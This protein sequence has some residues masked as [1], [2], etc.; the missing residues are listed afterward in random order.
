MQG[1][2]FG[3]WTSPVS[4]ADVAAAD[5]HPNWPGFVGDEVWWSERLPMDGGRTTLMRCPSG[6]GRPRS[7][8]PAPWSVR[9]RLMEYGGRAWCG[10]TTDDG[11]LAVFVHADD[12]RLYAFDPDEPAAAPRPVTPASPPGV[13]WRFADLTPAAPGGSAGHPTEVWCVRESVRRGSAPRREIV[14]VPLDGSACG[15]PEAVRVLGGG[16]DFCSG[17]ALAPDA[18]RAAWIGWD[19]PDMPWDSS[20]AY[21]ADVL[22]DG[23]LGPSR[24]VAGGPREAVAQVLWGEDGTLYAITDRSGWW[25]IH[26]APLHGG[27]ATNVCPRQEEFAGGLTKLGLTWA[28]ALPGGRLAVL[29][30][31]HDV[32]LSVLD[33]KTGELHGLN[34]ARTEW[35]PLLVSRGGRLVAIGAG[36]EQDYTVTLF[37]VTAGTST[38]LT[39][40]AATVPAAYLPRPEG[41]SFRGPDGRLVHAVVCPPRNPRHTGMPGERPPFVVFAH[42]G[43]T[44]RS[45]T[46]YDL[47]VAYLTSRGIGVVAV[48]YAGSTG[49][50]RAYREQLTHR[51]GI[52]DVADCALVAN[53]LAEE[54]TAD[55]DRLAI[56]GASAGGWTAAVS[57]TTQD[58]Y[59]CAALLYPVLDPVAWRAAQN[60]GF[61]AY[62]LD[63]LIGPWPEARQQFLERS[64]AHA[65][66]RIRAP[67]LLLQGSDDPICPPA[68]ADV[69]LA[70]VRDTVPFTRRVFDGERHGFKRSETVIAALEAELALY[71]E[72]FV[73]GGHPADRRAGA[74]ST[75]R[76]HGQ[77][78]CTVLDLVRDQARRT[79]D[80]VAVADEEG[81]WTYGELLRSAAESARRLGA[82]GARPGDRVAIYLHR[83]RDLVA[84]MLAAWTAGCAY[85]PLDPEYPADRLAFMLDDTRPAAVLTH[86]GLPPLLP[87]DD[88]RLVYVDR[89]GD[90]GPD[91]EGP[92]GAED[93]AF[94][95]Y[96]SGSTGVPKGV[97]LTHRGIAAVLHYSQGHFGFTESDAVLALA[98]VS[99]DFAQLEILL[100][101]ISGGTVHLVDR[102]AAR[103]PHLLDRALAE[104]GI[105]FLMG[106]PSLFAALTAYGWEPPA[107][108]GIVSGG[109]A[110]TPALARAL[111]G[112]RGL[113]NIYG[114][115]ETSVYALSERVSDPDDI[116]VGRPSAG[117]VIEILRDGRRCA[118]GETGEIHIGGP[119]LAAGYLDRPE[120]TAERFVPD[121]FRAGALLYRTGDL[122]RWRPDGRVAYEGRADEQ[123]KIRGHR[124]EPG[125]VEQQLLR[126]T[127]VRAAAVVAEQGHH[128][129]RLVAYLVTEDGSEPDPGDIRRRLGRVLPA[130]AVPQ[131]V[132]AVREIPLSPNGKTDRRALSGL[133]GA[134]DTATEGLARIVGD[135]LGVPEVSAADNFFLLGGDSLTAME[136]AIRAGDQGIALRPA[137]LYDTGTYGE[138]ADLVAARTGARKALDAVA[139]PPPAAAS[140]L[141]PA[142]HRFLSWD[143]RAAD[144]YNVTLAFTSPVPVDR[145]TLEQ[146]L[147]HVV[148]R[149]PALRLRL[150]G[151]EAATRPCTGTADLPL[152]WHR[153]AP[154]EA[155]E[156]S[157]LREADRL[158]RSLNLRAGPVWRAAYFERPTGGRLLMAFHHFVADG[159]S[160]KILAREITGAYAALAAGGPPPAGASPSTCTEHAAMLR[161]LVN[162]PLGELFLRRW[163]AL[164][165]DL[166]R[167]LATDRPEGSMHVS[168]VRTFETV[169]A[170]PAGAG[171]ARVEELVVQSLAAAAAQQTGSR[172]GAVEVCRHGRTDLTGGPG[173]SDAVGW[174]NSIAPYVLVLP[175]DG[176]SRATA[177][178]LGEQFADIRAM[179]QTWGAL[180]YL[181]GRD[182]VR[183]RLAALPQPDIYL[184]FLGPRMNDLALS[185]PFELYDGPVG[186]EMAPDRTQPYRVKVYATTSPGA[187]RLL[188]HYSADRDDE[189]RVRDLA[190]AAA[191]WF[192]RLS[193]PTAGARP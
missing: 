68:Q 43:P 125:E 110:L 5:S 89:D 47:Q 25:N 104:R 33:P 149:H 49:Y 133:P 23:R 118:P 65:A 117:A 96:T 126:L 179:E 108:L 154:G 103:D 26:R 176:S 136:V 109:E 100:P 71:R 60:G 140:A 66:G 75:G 31:T 8:L 106:T 19:H 22:P 155:G 139:P 27:P 4:A 48:N 111:E 50:G 10:T 91:G 73:T 70:G 45:T 74:P 151:S 107:R 58:I 83:T 81:S 62:Y 38:D 78:M 142:Q 131:R 169:T 175:E 124:V 189:E 97:L 87:A 61:E 29:H 128:S 41:R 46:A 132:V 171:S 152:S 188:W 193:G 191:Q 190:R 113:W 174:L 57:L 52:A 141:S 180:R 101:L 80:R 42:S 134:A 88:P 53:A 120:L 72:S 93:T 18:A 192:D 122:A 135:V 2:P 173:F 147:S 86:T 12:Q 178:A 146:A 115:T 56:R 114:P 168:R 98:P 105:T 143:H 183:G 116:T 77:D 39:E 14:A 59:C 79:P 24:V 181:H 153:L 158:H 186:T 184:N 6:G 187:L 40:A 161:R 13:Q 156:R 21:V 51:W 90:G 160:L 67:F 16:S 167:E 63:T 32:R 9:S 138:L 129:L 17:P 166:L 123:V 177:A 182:D 102:K 64:P 28:A 150:T 119:G 76:E 82:A 85:L 159:M 164:G 99:F 112:A 30:G 20:R 145:E 36:P 44:A 144:H 162:G 84:G 165:W 69:L 7:V 163:E 148:R 1:T 92:A 130:Y 54:G 170:L 3:A 157:F 15:R 94:V 11:L 95:I 34:P 35:E 37:D 127:G 137:D 55:P 121:P 185:A 172:A